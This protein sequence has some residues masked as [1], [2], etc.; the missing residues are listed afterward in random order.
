MEREGD[1]VRV[2]GAQVND[3]NGRPTLA[4][5]GWT[6]LAVLERGDGPATRR[7][8]ARYGRDA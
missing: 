7:Q 1:E 3:H 8:T 5:D 2:I 6:R 4:A